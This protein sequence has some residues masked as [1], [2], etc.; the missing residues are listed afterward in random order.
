MKYLK[1]LFFLTF[2]PLTV[3]ADESWENYQ[4]ETYS[5]M[6]SIPGWCTKEKNKFIMDTLVRMENPI[7]LEIGVF[8]GRSMI[9]IMRTLQYIQ[10]GQFFGIDAWNSNEA[11]MGFAVSDPNYEWWRGLDYENL[12][13]CAENILHRHDFDHVCNLIHLNSSEAFKQFSDNT[14]DFI[15]LDGNHNKQYAYEDAK[16]FLPKLKNG[17]L[18]LLNDPNWFS[19]S[20]ALVFL[21][22]RCDILSDFN[23]KS[24]FLLLKKNDSKIDRLNMLEI[25]DAI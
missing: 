19:M 24:Q 18:I 25:R 1:F 4:A 3:E 22:E 20:K 11:V 7:C 9:S 15:H 10:G 12:H 14:F 16:N 2:I 23:R 13:S 6:E 17:G 21:L 5:M 8:A